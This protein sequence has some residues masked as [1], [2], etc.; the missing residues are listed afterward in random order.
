MPVARSA[1]VRV[2]VGVRVRVRRGRAANPNPDPNPNPNPNPNSNPN[3]NPNQ[4]ARSADGVV[5]PLL[6]PSGGDEGLLR[7][8]QAGETKGLIVFVGHVDLG[9]GS[10]GCD[11]QT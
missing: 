3:P 9:R 11:L 2:R 10:R 6:A 7:Q 5:A 1:D 8:Y 4:V